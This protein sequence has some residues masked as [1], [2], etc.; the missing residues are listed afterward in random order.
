MLLEL[1]HVSKR[2]GAMMV[3]P[4]LSLSVAEGDFVGVIGPNGAGKTTVFGLISGGLRCDAGAV[5][6][7]GLDVTALGAD[8]RCRAGIGRTFQIPHPFQGMTAYENALVAATFGAGLRGRQAQ[9]LARDAIERCGLEAAA[10]IL[11]A[12]LTLLQRKRLE[13]ARAIATRPRLLLLDEVAGGLTDGE[14]NQLLQ[15]VVSIHRSGV[16]VLW[17]EHLV[18]ALVSAAGRLVV[19][20]DGRLLSDGDPGSVMQ[21]RAVRETYLGSDIDEELTHAEH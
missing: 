7:G 2:Y 19:L 5:V 4:D 3:V 15:L 12:R 1:R 17:I 9:A 10:D 16:T 21:D 18:H 6:L 8:E 14:M 13:L 20:A 11:A